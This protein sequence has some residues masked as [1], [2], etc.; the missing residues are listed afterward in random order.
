MKLSRKV[1]ELAE[2]AT[3][4]V[5]AKAAR[6]KAEGVDVVSFGAGEPDFDTPAHICEAAID[7]LKHGKTK[8]PTP[9]FGLLEARQ[10]V[11]ASLLRDSGLT[12]MPE[13]VIVTSGGKEAAYLAFHAL[14][15][16]GDEIVIPAPYWVSYPEMARLAGGVPV[17]V[18][19]PEAN[20]YKLTPRILESVLTPRTRI[21]VLNSPSNP[22]GVT[23][24]PDEV[25]A[26]ASVLQDREITVVSDEIYD[27]LLFDGQKTLSYAAAGSKA[28]VQT[29]TLNSASKT[30]AMT[31]WRLGYAAGPV[32]IIRAMA[33]LQSQST[34]G[35]ATFGQIAYAA[36]LTGDQSPVEAMR[37]EFERRGQHMW[38]RLTSLKGIRCPKPTGAF[39]CFP[40]VMTS[41]AR[42]RVNG[43]IPFAERLLE[44]GRVAVVP[45]AAFGMD[46]HV[47]LSFATS[48][49]QIDK[50]LDRMEALLRDGA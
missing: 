25:R 8:Y 49:E 36:A 24:H 9:G 12:Y 41:F 38:Q 45:G 19:G 16:P 46:E 27:R 40:N 34:S 21:F 28:Y 42:L 44:Q 48:M 26:L 37:A 43:S 3:L 6:M 32:E 11:S 23:Y 35:A 17:H 47:R 10:A 13:Q 20:D 2:S 50:G 5:S 39:Y 29:L 18:N 15:D 14:L 31:G 1:L 30:Y 22:S 33:K 7:A 4:A